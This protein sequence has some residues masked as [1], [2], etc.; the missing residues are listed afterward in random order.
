ML[1]QCHAP[2]KESR[3]TNATLE[4][5]IHCSIHDKIAYPLYSRYKKICFK[6]SKFNLE[7]VKGIIGS[8]NKVIF[9]NKCYNVFIQAYEARL[10][11]RNKCIAPECRDYGHNQQFLILKNKIRNCEEYLEN[12]Y[13]NKVDATSCENSA[14][15][16]D[17]IEEK[18]DPTPI[19]QVKTFKKKRQND[20]AETN[21]T[22]AAYIK[23]NAKILK[24]KNI[25]IDSCYKNMFQFT[26][27]KY[28]YEHMICMITVITELQLSQ[29]RGRYKNYPL[30]FDLNSKIVKSYTDVRNMFKD[31]CVGFILSISQSFLDNTSLV[32]SLLLDLACF[33]EEKEFDPNKCIFEYQLTDTGLRFSIVS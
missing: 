10:L 7:E 19:E 18:L 16:E 27:G 31:Q 32:L 13:E 5:R 26:C 11:H 9:L 21:K 17:I 23:E 14:E 29:I 4:G 8:K 22:I 28:V 25:L 1:L 6:A 12:I 33:W 24:Y 3:C 2:H 30:V 20:E 15:I